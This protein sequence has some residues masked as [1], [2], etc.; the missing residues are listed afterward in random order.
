M[1]KWQKKD[2]I[3]AGSAER[4]LASFKEK[5]ESASNVKEK[6]RLRRFFM[7]SEVG[8]DAEPTKNPPAV[9]LRQ[10]AALA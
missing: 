4:R 10:S 5:Q 7:E 2:R 6:L 9:V 3:F 1:A 8:D